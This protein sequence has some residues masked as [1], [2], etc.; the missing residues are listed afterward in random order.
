[1]S[2]SPRI[3][4]WTP[5]FGLWV[6]GL[7][8]PKTGE[9]ILPRCAHR[10]FLTN[11]RSLLDH[12]DAV[13]FHVRDWGVEDVPPARTSTQKWVWW[14]ME[15]PDHTKSYGYRWPENMFN[16]TMS[17]RRDSDVLTPYGETVKKSNIAAKRDHVA[18]WRLKTRVAIWLVSRCNT[19][20]GRE[21]YTEELRK[22][23]QVDIYGDCGDHQCSKEN[24]TACYREFERKYFFILAFE[25]SICRDYVTEKFFRALD[26]DLV[27]VVFG[28][29]N[30][31]QIA[32]PGSYIDALS[33]R[34]PRDLAEYLQKV[35]RNATLYASFFEWK[36][37]FVIQLSTVYDMCPLCAKLHSE[38][39]KK[40]TS[41]F[42]IREWWESGGR[43]RRLKAW[44]G[45]K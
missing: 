8:S 36:R 2:H 11:D 21:N 35:A 39:F 13:V 34:S 12:S 38:D 22:H 28:G 30:Y 44:G 18:L 23:V 17:Y 45:Y 16:W 27:P 31:S 19:P 20:S 14:T 4:L 32:P 37:R 7:D 6:F 5:W 41:Y 40:R 1:P 3:L 15:S 10:C 43:C 24:Y 42:D 25:N 9:V 29:A 33:F 26:F